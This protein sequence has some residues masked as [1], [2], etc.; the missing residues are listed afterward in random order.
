MEAVS[1]KVFVVEL[2]FELDSLEIGTCLGYFLEEDY[3]DLVSSRGSVF[4]ALKVASVSMTF[5]LS[6]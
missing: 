1:F 5:C 3:N 4:L 2:C 6:E